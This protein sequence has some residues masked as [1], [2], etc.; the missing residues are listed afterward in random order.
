MKKIGEKSK[1]YTTTGIC[2][3]AFALE[4]QGKKNKLATAPALRAALSVCGICA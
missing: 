2:F 3:A 1:A 4:K